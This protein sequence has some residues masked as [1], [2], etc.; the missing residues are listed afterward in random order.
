MDALER[1]HLIRRSPTVTSTSPSIFDD[2]DR[3]IDNSTVGVSTTLVTDSEKVVIKLDT[4]VSAG[5]A[6]FSQGQRQLLTLARALLR[7]S[8]II[9]LDEATSSIDHTTDVEIQRAI[10]EECMWSLRSSFPLLKIS[11]SVNDSL[12]LTSMF[13]LPS[14]EQGIT[15]AWRSCTSSEHHRRRPFHSMCRHTLNTDVSFFSMIA[16][17]F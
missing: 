6:N 2:G 10:R 16:C 4:Q 14:P 13:C 17:S 1:V 7:R 12:L 3:N 5:G 8:T 15:N 11:C 9:I